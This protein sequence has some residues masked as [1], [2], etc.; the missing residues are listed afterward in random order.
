MIHC[1]CIPICDPIPTSFCIFAI[2]SIRCSHPPQTPPPP[3]SNPRLFCIF[4]NNFCQFFGH[5]HQPPIFCRIHPLDPR[6]FFLFAF[7]QYLHPPDPPCSTG[8]TSIRPTTPTFLTFPQQL[9]SVPPTPPPPICF[10]FSQ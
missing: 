7:S 10:A 3:R 8:I 4:Q 1:T 2:T 5:I 6:L 9:E